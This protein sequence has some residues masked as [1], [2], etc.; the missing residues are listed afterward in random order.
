[1]TDARF[2]DA[3]V[4]LGELRSRAFNMRWA[5]QPEGVIPLTAADP[6]FRAAP[7]IRDALSAEAARGVYAYGPAGGLPS[8]RRSVST[9]LR[10]HRHVPIEP[11]AVIAVNSAAAGLAMVA[12]HWL[13]PGD[14]AIIMDPVD[15]LF[16]HTVRSAGGM[17]VRWPIARK[18]DLDLDRLRSLITPRT[19]MIGLCNPHNPLGRCFARV[20]LESIATIALERGVR[21]LSDEIWSEIIYRPA[22]F[23]SALALAPDLAAN[24]VVVH[25][26]SKSFGLAGCRIGYVAMLDAVK[27]RDMLSDSEHPSTV[28]GAATLSQIAAAAA[29]DHALPWLD[30]F[31]EHLHARR[32]QCVSALKDVGALEVESPEATYVIFP[33]VKPEAMRSG[34]SIE[35]LVERIRTE[36]KVAIVP[37][38]P[39]WFG[40]GAVGHV[41]LCYA[42]SEGILAEGLRRF[43]SAF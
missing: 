27:R 9:Y 41:R 2:E 6:D 14:E 29:Y 15:F 24:V 7:A 3:D 12:R 35:R 38:S 40:E 10:T 22:V 18:G 25:G 30:A 36:H 33:K 5:E 13:R 20:E 31:L 28:D 39:R 42:T 34:E 23:T 43:A 4:P 16:E 17:P 19:R 8:F 37:G 11:D 1:M 32:D 21:V 26:F